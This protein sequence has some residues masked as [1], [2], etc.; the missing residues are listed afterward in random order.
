MRKCNSCGAECDDNILFCKYCGY[1]LEE[2][3]LE[4]QPVDEQIE[5]ET[6]ESTT[7]EE[8]PEFIECEFC[9]ETVSTTETV[10]TKCGAQLDYS[11][12]ASLEEA[13]GEFVSTNI[14]KLKKAGEKGVKKIKSSVDS[15]KTKEIVNKNKKWLPFVGAAVLVLIILIIAVPKLIKGSK[16]DSYG[17]DTLNFTY[18]EGNAIFYN[19]QK[20]I[21]EVDNAQY[22]HPNFN[23]SRTK[24]GAIEDEGTYEGGTLYLIDSEGKKEIDDDVISYVISDNGNSV[25][26]FKDYDYDE[27]TAT[28]M[29]YDGKKSKEIE[30][31]IPVYHGNASIVISP[32]GSAV[33]YLEYEDDE[34]TGYI[35]VNGKSP[36]KLGK[37]KICIALSDNAKYV[38]Y[39]KFDPIDYKSEIYVKSNDDTKLVPD[40]MSLDE[41]FFNKD[42]SQI[43][44]SYDYK[45]YISVKGNDKKKL[46][47][48]SS[49]LLLPSNTQI[50]D[51]GDGIQV[52]GIKTFADMLL[53]TESEIYYLNGKFDANRLTRG[54]DRVVISH[55]M[56]QV[57]FTDYSGNLYLID[58]IRVKD[59]VEIELDKAEDVTNLVYSDNGKRIYY[60]NEDEELYQITKSNKPKKIAD[61]VEASRIVTLG[62]KLFFLVDYRDTGALYYTT[63][64]NK[65][66]V[67]D[68]DEVSY[69]YRVGKG[70]IYSYRD[71][72]E[73]I[74]Y[75]TNNGAKI[76]KIYEID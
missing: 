39:I 11:K 69:L 8:E 37:N 14:K 12:Q 52:V 6:T 51:N 66:E 45:T 67:K 65:V 62:D 1:K 29:L 64:S 30:D 28:L 38:Y 55:D 46:F 74:I 9:G 35:S 22:L 10:C 61:D 70:I 27:N 15:D 71:G 25:A 19:D 40:T 42:Y 76:S 68:A 72:D 21:A 36:E 43:I 34:Y 57:A 48:D 75:G 58:K 59:P 63:G 3:A 4:D 33:A 56:E 18:H 44:F 23:L 20:F 24:A 31:D 26:Y 2:Q 47:G 50:K 5:P 60:V 13:T 53:K 54:Y 49:T 17:K 16:L 41:I 7:V 73:Q 32:N